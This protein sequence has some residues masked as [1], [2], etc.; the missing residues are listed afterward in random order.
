MVL[1]IVFLELDV[2]SKLG[3]VEHEH[4]G[5]RKVSPKLCIL[6]VRFGLSK[7]VF[8]R[9]DQLLLLRSW[10]FWT[11]VH[12]LNIE[13]EWLLLEDEGIITVIC[14]LLRAECIMGIEVLDGSFIGEVLSLVLTTSLEG[15]V[16]WL[17]SYVFSLEREV[18]VK[19]LDTP[20]LGAKRD[21][22]IWKR[23][24]ILQSVTLERIQYL[25]VS[26]TERL[27]EW[28]RAHSEFE[29][30]WDS[31]AAGWCQQCKHNKKSWFKHYC[32]I[33]LNL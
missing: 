23:L 9:W 32:N 25:L 19:I 6:N 7:S 20:L 17:G 31:F 2:L 4:V 26:G 33:N 29:R 18:E 13:L 3:G 10:K 22:H 16:V 24:R 1:N 15:K 12:S 14:I 5:D 21:C 8:D 27:P 28:V 30:C 11:W